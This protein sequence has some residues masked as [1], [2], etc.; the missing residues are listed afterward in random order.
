MSRRI[1]TTENLEEDDDVQNVF[2]NWNMP[3]EEYA[4]RRYRHRRSRRADRLKQKIGVSGFAS[5]APDAFFC[6]KS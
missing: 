1:I 3:E 6:E 2:H 5:A 4:R